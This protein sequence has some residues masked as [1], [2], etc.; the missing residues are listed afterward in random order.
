MPRASRA[1]SHLARARG[2]RKAKQETYTRAFG[3]C[4]TGKQGTHYQ[5]SAD[6]VALQQEMS[7]PDVASPV[8]FEKFER[9]NRNYPI[10]VPCRRVEYGAATFRPP[11]R[12][13]VRSSVQFSN[14]PLV[15]F[16]LRALVSNMLANKV[17]F[18]LDCL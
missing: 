12:T 10:S 9:H 5:G 14:R 15:G 13:K 16:S 8:V 3:A 11:F 4:R 2:S 18:G 6:A 7:C 1:T 17:R